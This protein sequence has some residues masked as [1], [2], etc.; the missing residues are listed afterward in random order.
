VQRSLLDSNC[1]RPDHRI[2]HELAET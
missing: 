1:T 2:L